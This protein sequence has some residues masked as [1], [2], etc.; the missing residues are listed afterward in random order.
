MPFD[1]VL[2]MIAQWDSTHGSLILVMLCQVANV[3]WLRVLS[4]SSMY[5]VH[6]YIGH[7]VQSDLLHFTMSS[8]R[9]HMCLAIHWD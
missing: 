9:L 8:P 2:Q 5:P 4:I 7:A 1:T 3:N 6:L